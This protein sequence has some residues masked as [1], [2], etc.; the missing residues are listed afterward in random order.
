VPKGWD[1]NKELDTG[2]SEGFV[3]KTGKGSGAWRKNV[4][5]GRPGLRLAMGEKKKVKQNGD[6]KNKGEK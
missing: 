6:N 5:M 4:K 1:G 2:E 3:R